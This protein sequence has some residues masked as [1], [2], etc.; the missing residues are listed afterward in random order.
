MYYNIM[1][2]N[3]AVELDKELAMKKVHIIMYHYVRDLVHSRDPGTG[4][5]PVYPADGSYHETL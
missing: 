5:V 2:F 3:D 4:S 1:W